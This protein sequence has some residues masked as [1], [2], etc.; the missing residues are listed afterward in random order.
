MAAKKR[1]KNSEIYNH[2]ST[3]IELEGDNLR[4]VGKELGKVQESERFAVF[5]FKEGR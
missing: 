3:A 5:D 2:G 4:I 1:A